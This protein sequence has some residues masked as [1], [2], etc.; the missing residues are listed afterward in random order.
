MKLYESLASEHVTELALRKPVL[1][2]G[3]VTVRAAIQRMQAAKL[4][5]A[6]IVDAD[7]RPIGIFTESMLTQLLVND[8]AAVDGPV[9][10]R[11][12]EQCPVV[13]ETNSVS[14]VLQ[15]LQR[16]NTRFLAVVNHEG[17]VTGLTGQKGLMEYVADHFPQQVL[18]QRVGSPPPKER[19]G[20]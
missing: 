13:H 8:P 5:C 11:M 12:S 9:S 7:H 3:D 1:C 20:A 16:E 19:E 4:G 14:R 2:T 10:A 17:R 15:A 18:V 6:I